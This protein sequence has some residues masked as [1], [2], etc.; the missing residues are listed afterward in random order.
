[1]TPAVELRWWFFACSRTRHARNLSGSQTTAL[2]EQRRQDC[3]RRHWQPYRGPVSQRQR[4]PARNR[5][6][7]Q[8]G[9]A[10]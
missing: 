5:G 9:G 8:T 2:K 1:M 10:G 7:G 6:S 4:F 3:A